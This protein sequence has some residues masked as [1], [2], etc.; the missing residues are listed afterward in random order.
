MGGTCPPH[1]APPAVIA[2]SETGGREP[3]SV[4]WFVGSIDRSMRFS[5]HDDDGSA[6]PTYLLAEGSLQLARTHELLTK[7]EA[8]ASGFA[9]P[10]SPTYSSSSPCRCHVTLCSVAAAAVASVGSSERSRS[11]PTTVLLKVVATCVPART[12]ERLGHV[13]GHIPVSRRAT[14]DCQSPR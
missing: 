11:G 5:H 10:P 6:K 3:G 14:R 7:E 8:I 9:R 2:L 13:R 4:S 1:E 12:I